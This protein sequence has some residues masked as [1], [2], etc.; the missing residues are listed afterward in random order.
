MALA[1][2]RQDKAEEAR[3]GCPTVRRGQRHRHLYSHENLATDQLSI[4]KQL[5][6]SITDTHGSELYRYTYVGL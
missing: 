3:Q 4:A 5:S 2:R 1:A 6:I